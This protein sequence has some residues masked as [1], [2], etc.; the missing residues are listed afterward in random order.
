MDKYSKNTLLPYGEAIII[1]KKV[2]T[3]PKYVRNI[4]AKAR[5]GNTRFYGEKAKKIIRLANKT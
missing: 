4:L 2:K 3:T 5:K 1:A